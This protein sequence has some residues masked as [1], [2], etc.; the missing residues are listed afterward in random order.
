MKAVVST[1]AAAR[2]GG[3]YS[4]GVVANG[5]FF[6]AG[7]GAANPDD[8]P[9]P[10]GITAQT[11]ATLRN[12]EV[13]LAEVGLDL[14]DVVKATVHL[15]DLGDF[16][17]F[18]AAYAE[19]MPQPYPVRTAVRADLLGYLVEIDVIAALRP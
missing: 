2:P 4:Q 13:M 8:G 3:S 5:F 16:N 1:V 17:A 14:G 10:E 7:F 9:L 11:T 12:I 18:N 19:L 6:T 15:Q